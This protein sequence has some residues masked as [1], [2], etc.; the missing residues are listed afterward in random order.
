M[1]IG[2]LISRVS[3]GLVGFIARQILSDNVAHYTVALWMTS[4]I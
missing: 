3:S 2:H 1:A 4:S